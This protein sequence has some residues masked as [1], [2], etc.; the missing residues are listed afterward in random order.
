MK[1]NNPLKKIVQICTFS[2]FCYAGA[3][4]NTAGGNVPELSHASRGAIAEDRC[5]PKMTSRCLFIKF[6]NEN[7]GQIIVSEL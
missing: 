2:K 7:C 4:S 1:S 5:S 6:L 3:L